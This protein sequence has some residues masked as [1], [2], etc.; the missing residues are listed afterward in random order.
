MLAESYGPRA[1]LRPT[2][3]EFARAW[4]GEMLAAPQAFLWRQPFRERAIEDQVGP[5]V[6]GKR[7]VVLVHGFFCNRGIWNPLLLRLKRAGVPFIAVNLEPVLGSIDDYRQTI[8]DAV[9]RLTEATS[10]PPVIVSHSMGG[11]AVRAWLATLEDASAVH[12]VVTVASPHAGTRM[13]RRSMARNVGQMRVGGEWLEDLWSREA[14]GTRA[15]FICF[16][17]HCDNI[18]FPTRTA[19]LPEA[20]N[21]HLSATAHVQMALHPEVI[22]TVLELAS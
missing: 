19:T 21:R 12:R 13:A 14:P 8:S 10:A 16:W 11:L 17:G 20:D 22:A 3:F 2:Y 9:A 5:H 15:K 18:V 4:W 7:G 6:G 1:T